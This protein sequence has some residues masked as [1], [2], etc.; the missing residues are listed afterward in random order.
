M[1]MYSLHGDG[2]PGSELKHAR[3]A[4]DAA[5]RYSRNVIEASLDPFVIVDLEGKI[6][7]V[8]E[9]AVLMTGVTRDQ[10]IGSE[11]FHYV[12]EPER[13]RAGFRGVLAKGALRDF[14]PLTVRHVSGRVTHA[15]FNGSLYR[16]EQGDV[17]S[18]VVVVRDITERMRA[19]RAL[20][21]LSRANEALVRTADESQLLKEMCDVIVNAGGYAMAR[22]GF[23]EHDQAKTIRL[24]AWA[25]HEAGYLE[26]AQISWADTEH[27]R[28]P[29]GT[30]IRTGQPQV[31]QNFA[32]SPQM[33][34]WRAAALERGYASSVALPLKIGSKIIGAL[35]IYAAEPDAFDGDELHLLAELADDLSYGIAALR[36]RAECRA[37]A[38]ALRKSLEATVTALAGMVELRDPYTAGHQRNVS[39]LAAAIARDMGLSEHDIE[40]IRLAGV[41]HD[42]GK[43]S[44]PAEILSKSGKLNP[45]E[46]EFIK[47]HAQAGHDI[48]KDVLFPWPVAQMILQH[49][50]RL[51]GSG[52]PNGVKGDEILLGA[53]IIA[54]ADVVEAMMAH[55]PYRA[56]L[57][58][59]AALA[60]IEA[61]K[62]TVY[63]PAVVDACRALFRDGR[64]SFPS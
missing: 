25:G 13:A 28:G 51:D 61:G 33:V 29:T 48:I 27:G 11:V 9:A 20:K 18:V 39:V 10:L 57:G 15:L 46:F 31:N 38:Q 49:H 37:A 40:G 4:A 3:A 35:T 26:A 5:A 58:L 8:N 62:G 50:E 30:A 16:D 32:T 42:I 64:F 34:P 47:V 63:D 2:I 55:R 7:D 17:Q 36:A 23:A 22:I 45:I 1:A 12:T 21:T 19:E 6:T 43:I 53:R 60:E 41:V 56:A 44:V 14:V 24:M 59:D 52:Y 54:V